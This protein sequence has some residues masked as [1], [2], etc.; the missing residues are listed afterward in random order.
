MEKADLNSNRKPRLLLI[1]DTD[2]LRENYEKSLR[3]AGFEVTTIVD[4][5]FLEE[6][7]A[8]IKN[9]GDY[10]AVILSDTEMNDAEKDSVA[11]DIACRQAMNKKMID[12]EK[13]LVLGM[14]ENHRNQVYWRGVVNH[15]GFYEKHIFMPFGDR[16]LGEA[17][18]SH[19]RNF[20]DPKGSTIWKGRLPLIAAD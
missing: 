15:S 20:S 7:L 18:M 13:T 9:E 16:N 5:K 2:D 6:K 3:E 1:E 12:L 14:S 8:L 19:Y 4:G 11:G 10:F 17:V